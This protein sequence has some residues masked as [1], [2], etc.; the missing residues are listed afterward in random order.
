MNKLQ[1]LKQGL[2]KPTFRTPEKTKR[3]NEIL[4]DHP[5]INSN[6]TFYRTTEGLVGKSDAIEMRKKGGTFEY[7]KFVGMRKETRKDVVCH[8][9]EEAVMEINKALQSFHPMLTDAD[10]TGEIDWNKPEKR[11]R[12]PKFGLDLRLSVD[13]D[14]DNKYNILFLGNQIGEIL[15]HPYGHEH[16]ADCGDTNAVLPHYNIIIDIHPQYGSLHG[17]LTFTK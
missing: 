11:I 3:I 6:E 9:Q 2:N 12:L 5:D 14:G 10:I 8:T 15:Y 7:T 1:T 4:A 13:K 17:H 16:L